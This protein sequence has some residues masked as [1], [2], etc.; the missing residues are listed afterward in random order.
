[1]PSPHGAVVTSATDPR[2]HAPHTTEAT[3]AEPPSPPAAP[4]T[5]VRPPEAAPRWSLPALI[6]IMVLA[7]VLY[8]W[9]LSSSGLN[10]FYSAAVL[11]G[12]ES[13]KAWFFGSPDAGNLLTTDK[14]PFVL[15][16]AWGRAADPAATPPSAP[17]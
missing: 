7:G 17:R 11:S 4:A 1:M 2:P 9:N 15:M 14:P 16:G 10:S 5:P 6:G 12:T 8:S 13:W 3:G